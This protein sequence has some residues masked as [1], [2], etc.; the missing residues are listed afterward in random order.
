MG[1]VALAARRPGRD[2]A[3]AMSQEKV[4]VVRRVFEA[5]R[6]GMERGDL[7]AWFDSE[8]IADEAEWIT[9]PG[10]LGGLGTYRGREGFLEFMRIWTENFE[11]WSVELEGLIDAD[12]D[13]VVGLFRQRATGKRSGV[14]VEL[15]QALVYELERGRVIRIRNY[16]DPAEALKAV[17]LP[18]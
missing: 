6:K 12:D 2:T 8:D 15:H 16:I 9:P 4:E 11:D 14:P 18:E 7:G 3:G 10:A 17:G 13:R 1:A 5:F